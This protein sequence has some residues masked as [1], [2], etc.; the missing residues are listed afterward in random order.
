MCLACMI[1]TCIAGV[2]GG[3]KRYDYYKGLSKI[4][5][6]G[7]TQI[8][9][10]SLLFCHGGRRMFNNAWSTKSNLIKEDPCQE[11]KLHTLRAGLPT[12][13][14]GISFSKRDHVFSSLPPE[15]WITTSQG[16]PGQITDVSRD[17]PLWAMCP[18]L[19]VCGTDTVGF[20]SFWTRNSGLSPHVWSICL[21]ILGA[22]TPG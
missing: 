20:K 17:F 2:V 11:T 14:L 8:Q 22:I 4:N 15:N 1:I 10:L 13:I 21:C 3:I 7:P 9:G 6:S 5:N 12:I 19:D 18:S 16:G